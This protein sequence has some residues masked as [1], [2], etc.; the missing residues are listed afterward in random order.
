M[1]TRLLNTITVFKN[2][3]F[4]IYD[5]N[6][7]FE[8]Y[9]MENSMKVVYKNENLWIIYENIELRLLPSKIITNTQLNENHSMTFIFQD[10]EK[11]IIQKPNTN[12]ELII[13]IKYNLPCYQDNNDIHIT[14]FNKKVSINQIYD[15]LDD[16]IKDT[17]LKRLFY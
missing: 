13:K 16:I 15:N 10:G 5:L 7:L 9:Y 2:N 4:K 17:Y 11:Y 3:I 12:G 6:E 14:K 1:P 8:K